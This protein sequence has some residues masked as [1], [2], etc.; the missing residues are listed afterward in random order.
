MCRNCSNTKEYGI[1]EIQPG[2]LVCSFCGLMLED[3]ED[4]EP[5]N[6]SFIASCDRSTLLNVLQE[7]VVCPYC[8]ATTKPVATWSCTRCDRPKP[9]QVQEVLTTVQRIPGKTVAWDF[10]LVRN[11]H[12]GLFPD[13]FR[14]PTIHPNGQRENIPS[15]IQLALQRIPPLESQAFTELSPPDQV[16]L[17][18]SSLF[19]EVEEAAEKRA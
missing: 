11:E 18:G 5:M 14:W 9:T 15:P 8:R 3:E 6:D 10:S 1:L 13:W 2:G 7:E 16:S 4:N 17:I 19:D 12:I